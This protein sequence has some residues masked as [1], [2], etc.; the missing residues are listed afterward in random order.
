MSDAILQTTNLTKEFKGF[1]AV[2][3]VN[4]SVQRGSIHG[5]LGRIG[6]VAGSLLQIG[7]LGIGLWILCVGH[8]SKEL[9][10]TMAAAAARQGTKWGRA[11][12]FQEA[13]P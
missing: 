3:K 8:G 10:Q 1:T 6:G 2:S 9:G 12:R 7:L 11:M 5:G 13:Q 4:L